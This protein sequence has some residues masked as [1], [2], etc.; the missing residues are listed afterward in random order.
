[1]KLNDT[2]HAGQHAHNGERGGGEP[3][4][5]TRA[6]S[7][8][9]VRC[10]SVDLCARMDGGASS[11]APAPGNRPHPLPANSSA[12]TTAVSEFRPAAGAS[13]RPNRQFEGTPRLVDAPWAQGRTAVDGTFRPGPKHMNV[14]S[15]VASQRSFLAPRRAHFT[16]NFVDKLWAKPSLSRPIPFVKEPTLQPNVPIRLVTGF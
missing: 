3:R 14:T 7:I 5:A 11:R 6:L 15:R 8:R 1:M 13:A 12:V 9:C 16:K 2:R 4:E 10:A